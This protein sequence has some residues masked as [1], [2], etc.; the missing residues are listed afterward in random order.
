MRSSRTYFEI[1]IVRKIYLHWELIL[2]CCQHSNFKT[3]L[4][5]NKNSNN[6]LRT[7]VA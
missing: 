7:N 1:K 4:Y 6:K 5:K 2:T 3:K